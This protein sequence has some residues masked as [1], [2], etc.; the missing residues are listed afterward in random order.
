[1]IRKLLAGAI[2]LAALYFL[3]LGG[4]YSFLDIWRLDRALETETTELE[5][6]RDEVTR[7]EARV[8]SLASDS[9]TLERLAREQYGLIKEGERLYRFA[10]PDTADTTRADTA[11]DGG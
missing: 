11:G 5:T 4:E 1:M 10:E 9:A 2:V 7:L 3:V 8:D 6:V